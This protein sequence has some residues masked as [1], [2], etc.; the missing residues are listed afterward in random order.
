MGSRPRAF[1]W[2]DRLS[3]PLELG[4][5]AVGLFLAWHFVDF[6][7]GALVGAGIGM[8]AATLW[9]PIKR[10]YGINSGWGKLLPG[11][12]L[13]A[14]GVYS[15]TFVDGIVLVQAGFV[16]AGG[17]LVLDAIYDLTT[18]AG[19]T[20]PGS[21][22]PMEEFGDAAIVGRALDDEPRSIDEL[23]ATLDLSRA[24]IEGALDL[25]D[26]TDTIT[27][28]NGRYHALLDD[29]RLAESLRDAPSR[30]A[31]RLSGL[32]ARLARPLRLFDS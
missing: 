17:W 28:R 1:R 22:N 20:T 25:L 29:R 10:R 23:D 27:E 7:P 15:F 8:G 16:I 5:T 6:P 21:P 14:L 30:T 32:P 26:E 31:D 19:T 12:G 13:F 24:R 18:D 4:A 3:F 9:P 2:L 11:L